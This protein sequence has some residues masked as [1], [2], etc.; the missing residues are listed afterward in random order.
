[1][2]PSQRILFGNPRAPAPTRPSDVSK[3]AHE[4][5]RAMCG[6]CAA[7]EFLVLITMLVM[8]FD[9]LYI[10][11]ISVR[12]TGDSWIPL[13]FDLNATQ[14]HEGNLADP[15]N[16]LE[17]SIF[18]I[19]IVCVLILSLSST[20]HRVGPISG[21]LSAIAISHG[22]PRCDLTRVVCTQSASRPL[23]AWCAACA[24]LHSRWR[25]SCSLRCGSLAF[26]SSSAST[27]RNRTRYA[28]AF[29]PG[30]TLLPSPHSWVI[31]AAVTGPSH[32]RTPCSRH[33]GRFWLILLSLFYVFVPYFALL[34]SSAFRNPAL[35]VVRSLDRLPTCSCALA[36]RC[37]P[38][39]MQ[40][41]RT[42][43]LHKAQA[44]RRDVKRT[45]DFRN[46][47]TGESTRLVNH[48]RPDVRP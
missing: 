1:M 48:N 10:Y 35:C 6:L 31:R 15:M 43:L 2:E 19:D 28:R 8:I 34:V 7:K 40:V 25:W 14:I 32:S 9:A 47:K 18:G 41:L 37:P 11:F 38:S 24:C 13:P 30:V 20:R 27:R 22:A 4:E 44:F 3:G 5:A 21:R 33:L 26:A 23:V 36:V 39:P 16:W 29:S 17:L 46:L 45:H 42:Y 12:I